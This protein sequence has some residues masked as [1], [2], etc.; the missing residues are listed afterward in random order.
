MEFQ[1]TFVP[2]ALSNFYEQRTT[3]IV[4]IGTII[5]ATEDIYNDENFQTIAE[6]EENKNMLKNTNSFISHNLTSFNTFIDL[7]CTWFQSE[8][9][10]LNVEANK[11]VGMGLRITF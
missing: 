3:L 5:I 1:N 4:A 9:K 2:S 11:D 10:S 8:L 6:N 7:W